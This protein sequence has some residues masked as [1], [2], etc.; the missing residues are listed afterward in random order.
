MSLPLDELA[1]PYQTVFDVGAFRG[2]FAR[3]CL[4]RWKGCRVVSFEPLEVSP[5]HRPQA[6]LW[7]PIA[8][9]AQSSRMQINECEFIPSSSFLTMTDLHKR[10]FPFTRRHKIREVSMRRL[11]DYSDLVLGRAL[12]KVDVQG[13]ELQVLLGAG[14]TLPVFHAVVM[15]VSWGTLY[16]QTPSF[17]ELD[18]YLEQFGFCHVRR[19]AEMPHPKTGEILQSDELWTRP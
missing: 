3:A 14:K 1:G 19:V 9:G 7:F 15:E 2:D 6:W 18:S 8:L 16:E 10:A 4:D 5:P 17:D 13:Y 12:L 11:A